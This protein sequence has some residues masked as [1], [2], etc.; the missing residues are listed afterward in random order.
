MGGDTDS[1]HSKKRGRA[2]EKP[3]SCE[4][5]SETEEN[6]RIMRLIDQE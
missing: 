3:P 6:L 1:V 4:P 5:V 2:S